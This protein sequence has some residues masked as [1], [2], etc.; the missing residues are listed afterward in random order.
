GRRFMP[1]R[2]VHRELRRNFLSLVN[3]LLALLKKLD[4]RNKALRDARYPALRSALLGGKN[5]LRM[6]KIGVD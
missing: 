4:S 5:S 3:A 1:Q 6:L 2:P